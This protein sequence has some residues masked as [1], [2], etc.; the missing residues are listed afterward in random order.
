LPPALA[1]GLN[2]KGI[3]GFSREENISARSHHQRIF[4][5][6]LFRLPLFG[7]CSNNNCK[8]F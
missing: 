8:F 4:R 1:G 5:I 3:S 6:W 7:V 2:V